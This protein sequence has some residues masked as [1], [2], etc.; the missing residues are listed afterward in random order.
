MP[1]GFTGGGDTDLWTPLRPSPTGEGGGT[2]YALVARL[3]TR[4]VAR[5][6]GRRGGPHRRADPRQAVQ[7]GHARVLLADPLQAGQTADIRRPLLMLW[8]AV[9]LVLL[10]ACVNV[11]GLLIARS[12][13][14]T[15]EIATR[16]ALGS[17][18]GAVMRQLLVES[19]VLALA[20]GVAGLAVGWAVLDILTR[21]S[22][23]VLEPGYPI[24]LDARVLAVSL[25]VALATS[26]FFGLLPALQASRVDVTGAL[27]ESGTRSI[28]G[29]AG[30]LVA[31][32]SRRGGGGAGR[33]AARGRGPAGA[34]V[35]PP[36]RSRSGFRSVQRDDRDALA[37]GP[38]L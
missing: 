10:I 26:V 33:G 8:G 22:A 7:Q 35:R 29:S 38:A 25:A 14:R 11:A 2:N 27:V 12:G 18:R 21:L 32:R 6:G 1:A 36:A 23:H 28:A 17:G 13:L 15:H 4:C 30:P 37:A 19:A 34:D 9:G 3:A 5:A 20:G 31:A 16:M 24:T